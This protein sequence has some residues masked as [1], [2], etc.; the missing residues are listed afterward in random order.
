LIAISPLL[1]VLGQLRLTR[2]TSRIPT[3]ERLAGATLLMGLP[4][5]ALLRV[6][7][8]L[9]IVLLI[10]VFMLGE[11]VWMPTS[12]TVAARL[13]P[14]EL[15]GT[16]LGALAAMTGP[17]WTLA[18]FVAFSLRDHAGVHAVWILFAGIA[19]AAAVTGAAAVHAA[20]AR[21]A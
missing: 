13:A 12:Q 14:E 17:A 21:E 5:L 11:M 10:V 3:A 20:E 2:A 4:F 6:H 19:V 8:V 9:A 18:P 7:S 15:R 1:V 16:Y